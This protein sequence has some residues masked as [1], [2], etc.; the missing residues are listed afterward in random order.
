MLCCVR[1]AN[2]LQ[3]KILA[4][5]QTFLA[6][7]GGYTIFLGPM[8][9]ILMTEYVKVPVETL[10][11][12]GLTIFCSYYIVRRGKVSVPDMYW[13]HGMYRYSPKFA[14]N[15]RA[16]VAFLIGVLPPLPGFVNNIVAAGGSS[17]SISIGGQHL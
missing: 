8:T 12:F 10:T 14:S 1:A 7:L 3:W 5:A 15:W 9:S 13:F 17:T 6:F 11:A 4:S 2:K 16:V